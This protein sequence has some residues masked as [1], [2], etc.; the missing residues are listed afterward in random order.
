MWR[1]SDGMWFVSCTGVDN[2][3]QILIHHI[4]LKLSTPRY[5]RVAVIRRRGVDNVMK[6]D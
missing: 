2:V 6:I 3:N 4:E 5:H 1:Q